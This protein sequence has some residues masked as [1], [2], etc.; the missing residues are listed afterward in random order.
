MWLYYSLIIYILLLGA[1]LG[2]EK[3]SFFQKKCLIFFSFGLFLFIAAFRSEQIGND[4]AEYLR[5]F[6]SISYSGD[7]SRFAWR[8]E[9]GYLYLNRILGLLTSQEQSIIV[10]TSLITMLGFARFIYKYSKVPWLS[11]YLFFTLGYFSMFMNTIRLNIAIVLILYSFDFIEK[12]NFLKFLLIVIFASLFHRTAI[13]FLVAYFITEYKF[14]RKIIS[15]AVIVSLISF[16]IFPEMFSL[17]IRV[18]PTYSYYI[19]S[20]YLDGN[21]RIA[22]VLNMLVGL[23]IMFF[24]YISQR[25][26]NRGSL[27]NINRNS[28]QG[29][30]EILVDSDEKMLLL[31][32]IGVSVTFISFRFNL[33]DRVGEYFLVFSCVVLPN[34]IRKMTDKRT[35]LLIYYLVIVLFFIYSTTIVLFRPEWNIIYP[36]KFFWN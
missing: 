6:R 2:V 35:R 36:Y 13:V 7:I 25:N 33:L 31:I 23:S 32:L 16:L 12:R 28:K 3:Q 26:T 10:F 5:I 1:I 27:V 34:S 22:S 18:F 17:L 30:N 14:N 20:V 21:I 24:S 19:G 4:T 8:F 15:S 11:V 9:S 29:K